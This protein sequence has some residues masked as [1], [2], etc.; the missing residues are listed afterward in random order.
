MRRWAFIAC[1]LA[2]PAWSADSGPAL[3]SEL[4]S[5]RQERQ[6]A[7]ASLQEARQRLRQDAGQA[8]EGGSEAWWDLPRRRAREGRL[9]GLNHARQR[10]ELLQR[11]LDSLLA[12]EDALG[13]RL[14]RLRL[15][16]KQG[17][18]PAALKQA[19]D[20]DADRLTRLVQA[21]EAGEA[22]PK[23]LEL[24]RKYFRDLKQVPAWAEEAEIALKILR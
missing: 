9:R 20:Y 23:Q 15:E 8:S 17:L 7:Q 24:E 14:R 12:R 2:A 21:L 11:R 22:D 6:A 1:L 4:G 16:L 19:Q 10:L 3:A 18:D 13:Q 5:L